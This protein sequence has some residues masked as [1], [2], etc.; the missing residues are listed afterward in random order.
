MNG[1][2][3]MVVGTELALTELLASRERHLIDSREAL[4]ALIL[5][6]KAG[7]ADHLL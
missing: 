4:R 7:K 5:E 3:Q 1:R 6:L 2:Y